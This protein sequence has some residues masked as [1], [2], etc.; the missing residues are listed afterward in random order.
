[1]NGNFECFDKKGEIIIEGKFKDDKL[2]EK[3]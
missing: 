3:Y 2:I 1:M